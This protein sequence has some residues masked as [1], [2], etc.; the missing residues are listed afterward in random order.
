MEVQRLLELFALIIFSGVISTKISV[1]LKVPDVVL[2]IVAGIILGPHILNF[3]NIDSHP[4]GNELILTF[5][6]AYI[7]YDGGK[8]IELKVLNKVKLSLFIIATVGV[9]I[10]A[11]IIGFFASMIFK[12]NFMYAFLL[13]TVIASTDPSVLIPLFKKMSISNKL[14]QFIIAESAFN[15]AAGAIITFA[16]L[17]I[18]AGRGFSI[19][20]SILEL[21]KHP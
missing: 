7:L 4:I 20:S 8:E 14:K 5:G 15:D 17:G 10:S 11:F 9:L 21:V 3:V 18:I 6:A 12:I 2:F 19:E 16:T 13:G 1:M